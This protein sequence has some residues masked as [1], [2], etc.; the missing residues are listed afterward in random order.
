[1]H[2]RLGAWLVLLSVV[3]LTACA[4][5]SERTYLTIATGGTGGVYYPLG[6]ALA[7]IYSTTVAGVNASAQATAASVFNVQAVQQGK[8]DVAI[9]MGD[10][11]WF[12]HNRG[13]D[14]DPSPHT[15]LRAMAVLYP[16]AMHMVARRDSPIQSL[17]DFRGRRIGVGAPASGTEVSARIIMEAHDVQYAD[18][19]PDFLSFSEVASQMQDRTLDVGFVSASYPVSAVIDASMTVGI[20]LIPISDSALARIIEEF[21]F[22]KRIV[23]PAGT[24]RGQDGDVQTLGVDNL[25]VC[26]S[27]LDEELVYELTKT[28]FDSLP[29]LEQ[30]HVAAR[31]VDVAKV[32]SAPIPLHPGAERYY[33]ERGVIP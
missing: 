2:V 1:M 22:F 15:K 28:F 14:A 8:A 5:S 27:D 20:R 21:P 26:S 31:G 17:A 11:A 13:T 30:T 10:V 9:A 19:R 23:I 7:Q 33:R 18:V 12:A 3:A 29:D 32:L 4:G 24:Y 6:G 16:N 25:L